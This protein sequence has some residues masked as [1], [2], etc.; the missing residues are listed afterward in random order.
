VKR[1]LVR[2]SMRLAIRRNRDRQ[3]SFA[4]GADELSD[5]IDVVKF[6]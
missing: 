4:A 2:V 5:V 1:R 3:A 6:V